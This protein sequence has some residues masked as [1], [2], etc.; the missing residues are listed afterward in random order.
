MGIGLQLFGRL[1]WCS[2]LGAV[3]C[4]LPWSKLRS[5]RLWIQLSTRAGLLPLWMDSGVGSCSGNALALG[6]LL[7]TR[8][9]KRKPALRSW[10]KEGICLLLWRRIY[11]G[12]PPFQWGITLL[13][14]FLGRTFWGWLLPFL[15]LLLFPFVIPWSQGIFQRRPQMHIW[16]SSRWSFSSLLLTSMSST[17]TYTFLPI[18]LLNIWFTNLWYVAPAF[19]KPKGLTL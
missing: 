14:S 10:R 1:S 16:R 2:T 6:M 8:L 17:Y 11:W 18:Y 7:H 4:F 19:F 3:F 13:W 9:S 5:P 12:L 15:D